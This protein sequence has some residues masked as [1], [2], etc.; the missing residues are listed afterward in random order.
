MQSSE[1]L[2]TATEC[3]EMMHNRMNSLAAQI[4]YVRVE[5]TPDEG[6]TK[7][8][9]YQVYDG[10]T[11]RCQI[12]VAD[13]RRFFTKDVLIDVN[14][15]AYGEMF[16]DLKKQLLQAASGP[17]VTE[18][19][20]VIMDHTNT[21]AIRRTD[22]Q[23][24]F[25]KFLSIMESFGQSSTRLL[26]IFAVC[27]FAG[28][29]IP[30]NHHSRPRRQSA[31]KWPHKGGTGSPRGGGDEAV[32]HQ[33]RAAGGNQTSINETIS[34]LATIPGPYGQFFS[35]IRRELTPV[36]SCAFDGPSN[37]YPVWEQ[38]RLGL[39][40]AS[41]KPLRDAS[42]KPLLG[43]D[44]LEG[45]DEVDDGFT[46]GEEWRSLA[47]CYK[48]LH[49]LTANETTLVNLTGRV[50]AVAGIIR[51]IRGSVGL[52]SYNASLGAR[53]DAL[54]EEGKQLAKQTG[55]HVFVDYCKKVFTFIDRC[56]LELNDQGTS[57]T[58][59][60][61][62]F[63]PTSIAPA[64]PAVTYRD[65][66]LNMLIFSGMFMN[67]FRAEDMNAWFGADEHENIV[68]QM[69]QDGGRDDLELFGP[70]SA[71][72]HRWILSIA[73]QIPF[74][75]N[76]FNAPRHFMN[77]MNP[78]RIA[79][80]G[81]SEVR[82]QNA[83]YAAAMAEDKKY[84]VT[85]NLIHSYASQY[86]L[87]YGW[88][89]GRLHEA[90]SVNA[91]DQEKYAAQLLRALWREEIRIIEEFTG[92]PI[93]FD[94]HIL[95]RYRMLT[96]DDDLSFVHLSVPDMD[97]VNDLLQ[98]RIHRFRLE[99]PPDFVADAVGIGVSS[100]RHAAAASLDVVRHGPAALPGAAYSVGAGVVGDIAAATAAASATA[101][102]Q[103]D[104]IGYTDADWNAGL[105][106]TSPEE[107]FNTSNVSLK[108]HHPD[109]I[110]ATALENAAAARN[111]LPPA[112]D[113]SALVTG[114]LPPAADALPPAPPAT[115][116]LPDPYEDGSMAAAIEERR[117]ARHSMQ[118]D[119]RP[120]TG[121]NGMPLVS[122]CK[123][124]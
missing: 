73:S 71:T 66:Q 31:L 87:M 32:R 104:Y 108:L 97:T 53:L 2:R 113:A 28:S 12:L 68:T 56:Y 38:D 115:V 112:A 18:L 6:T 1:S 106:V 63:F 116:L 107:K 79:E 122:M 37:R 85:Y 10:V 49:P 70:V 84:F 16:Y 5:L 93:K 124:W 111:A 30:A 14:S 75:R 101:K 44:D 33:A 61:A 77:T 118:G 46:L 45:D 22:S 25:S 48:Q 24:V 105:V 20:K 9:K 29:F 90:R 4:E 89:K 8:G 86:T 92:V 23:H 109:P 39:I 21:S 36:S 88:L 119:Y 81:R 100:A 15:Q 121:P 123:L 35:L 13:I 19:V 58:P 42:G 114:T 120:K 69:R 52:P 50:S 80:L 17:D 72:E 78:D 55:K 110:T 26:M 11:R 83:K 64:P 76:V 96:G 74:F 59:P 67:W 91:R 27:I 117:I 60:A 43:V 34:N 41:G 40:D 57:S 98:L 47:E 51:D 99:L 102:L 82:A 62:S 103:R 65:S 3:L 54:M 95:Q 7:S 94:H